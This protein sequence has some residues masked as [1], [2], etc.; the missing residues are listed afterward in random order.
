MNTKSEFR[1][2]LE[3]NIKAAVKSARA[4]GTVA[5][6]LGN[7]FVVTRPPSASLKGAPTGTNATYRYMKML[8]EAAHEVAGRFLLT[9]AD[10]FGDHR[11]AEEASRRRMTFWT[12]G[13]K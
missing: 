9:T 8:D 12:G 6:S 10:E 13:A 5:M 11:P 4:D 1:V 2:A 7:F 3:A